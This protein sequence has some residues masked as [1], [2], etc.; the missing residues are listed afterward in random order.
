ML[1]Q[2]WSAAT[3]GI[4][5]VPV[6]IETSIRFGLPKYR[7]VGLP[8]GAVRESLDRVWAAIANSGLQTI[9]GAVTINLAP[10]DLRKDS[11][12]LDLPIALGLLSASMAELP[13]ERLD[14]FFVAG[15]LALDG[16]V[17][18]VDGVLALTLAAQ[19][20]GAPNVIV[21]AE[22][23]REASI[24]AG[25]KVFAVASLAEAVAAL[26]GDLQAF[27]RSSDTSKLRTPM[28][29]DM[30]D[31]AGQALAKRAVEVAAAGGHNLL[32]SG[33][34][35]SGKTMLAR[36]IPGL[37]PPL[38]DDEALETTL[39]Q[40][41]AGVRHGLQVESG[42]GR[43]IDLIRDRPFRSPHHTVSD[44]GMCGGGIRPRPGEV[45]LAHNGVLFLDELPEFRRS[46]LEAL[47]QPIEEGNISIGRSNASVYFPAR[48]ML[49]GSMNPC[50]CGFQTH[51]SRACTCSPPM[52]HRYLSRLSGPL[53]DRIDIRVDVAPVAVEDLGTVGAE[54]SQSIRTR[55]LAS[56]EVQQ[57]RFEGMTTVR[58]N[59]Q[60][61]S[62][63]CRRHCEMTPDASRLL[64]S[65]VRHLGLSARAYER[66]LKVGRTI[67]DLS[68]SRTLDTAHIGEAIQYRAVDASRREERR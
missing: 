61:P 43:I 18:P 50:P 57:H 33:P 67:A 27:S 63:L 48:F 25:I 34:P 29:A 4:E 30:A 7:V 13:S 3:V 17:R 38:T 54:N 26:T 15:E 51:P 47:R 16:T 11:S 40:S 10:A 8:Y 60:M 58:S 36:R 20:R 5:A 6:Q 65:A 21:P 1:S 44:A 35:G 45:S 66:V 28:P 39:I 68:G 31:V 49:V 42:S 23:G 56:R 62:A 41:V 64:S 53:M 32:L 14:R 19:D 46:V 2:V 24:V 9:H 52:V 55:V 59:A 12:G 22:N 37:L